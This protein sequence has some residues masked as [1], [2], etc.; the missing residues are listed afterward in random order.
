MKVHFLGIGGIGVSA[1]AQYYVTKGHQVS[2][3]DLNSSEITDFLAKLGVK[4]NIGGAVNSEMID[5]DLVIYSP[6]IKPENTEF[7]FYKEKGTKCFS[8][9]EALGELTKEYFTIAI[10]GS[11]GKSTTT[12]MTALAMIK[13]NLDP[14]VIVGTKLVEFGN[15]NFRMGSSNY[16]VIEACEYEESFLSYWPKIIAVTNIEAE[17]LDYFKNLKNVILAFQ[18]FI[19]HLPK[20]GVLIANK[21]DKNIAKLKTK[22]KIVNFKIKQKEALQI[23][24]ILKIPGQHNVYNA[25]AVL[26]IM[27]ELGVKD[28]IVLKSLAEYKGSWRRFET[29]VVKTRF[30]KSGKT[31]FLTVISDYGHHPTEVLATLKATR[32]KFPKKKI[33]CVFQPHQYQRTYLLFKD[34]VKVFKSAKIDSIIITDIYGVAG[35][36]KESTKVSSQKLVDAIKKKNTIYI[37]LSETENYVKQNIK[38]GDVLLIMGAGDIYKLFDKF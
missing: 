34:F 37:P 16:L 1:L 30:L 4:I 28:N 10:C 35:R 26:N 24:K 20:D 13:A 19:K 36:E 14:T 38:S 5:V 29:K 17:H 23:K 22:N 31:G 33:W 2:G 12:S 9:P 21:D 32:E 18:K 25:L 27:R 3:S 7:K 8:Y 6:A 11:H 15:T